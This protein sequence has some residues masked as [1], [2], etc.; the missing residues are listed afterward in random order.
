V[1]LKRLHVLPVTETGT[2]RVHILGVTAQPA[3]PRAAQQARNL[4]MDPG[5][6]A[7]RFKFLT[8][9]RDSTFTMAFDQV[10][11]G[12]GARIIKTPARS[13]R[14]DSYAERYAGTLRRECPDHLL[15]HGGR[16]PRRM[17]AEYPRHHNEHRPHQPRDQRPPLHEPGQPTDMTARINRTHV[18]HALINEYRSAA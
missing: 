8:R 11:A 1:F 10:P 5:G 14:A 18:V 4:L 13:P 7:A 17:L 3:G 9:D 12:N 16:H 2:R 15:I 6:R